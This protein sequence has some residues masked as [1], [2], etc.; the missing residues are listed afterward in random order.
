MEPALPKCTT[1]TC[2]HRSASYVYTARLSSTVVAS[3]IFKCTYCRASQSCSNLKSFCNYKCSVCKQSDEGKNDLRVMVPDFTSVFLS[4]TIEVMVKD[5]SSDNITTYHLHIERLRAESEYFAGLIRFC[6]REVVENVVR[7]TDTIVDGQS[8]VFKLFVEFLYCNDYAIP[9]LLKQY[10]PVLHTM[11]Y[12]LADRLL[13]PKLKTLAIQKLTNFLSAQDTCLDVLV[14]I[15]MIVVVYNNTFEKTYDTTA[16]NTQRIRKSVPAAVQP[17]QP[18]PHP[19]KKRKHDGK[20][21]PDFM[22]LGAEFDDVPTEIK[23]PDPLRTL[24][25]RYAASNLPVLKKEPKFLKLFRD[26]PE[27][28]ED[29]MLHTE[30]GMKSTAL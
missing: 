5:P 6:G 20:K 9:A 17:Q 21:V 24:V 4:N 1:P 3:P 12:I 13:A 14:V 29:M 18:A 8:N 22:D 25:S 30:I 23:N 28:A 7:L 19:T 27:F 10:E 16:Q 26:Y 15:K 2:Q 11:T